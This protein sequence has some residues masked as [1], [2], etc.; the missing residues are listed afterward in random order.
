MIIVGVTGSFSS[1][2]SAVAAIFKKLGAK[3]FDADLAAHKVTQKGTAVH[4]AIIQIFGEEFLDSRGQLDRKKLAKRVF[5]HPRDLQKLNILV[6]P[7]VI[8]E[9]LKVIR[10]LKHKKGILVLDV[11]LL[12]EARMER[13]AD[14][15]VVVNSSQKEMIARA[16]KK[17]AAPALSRKILSLQ[18]PFSKKARHADYVIHNRGNMK[19]LKQE[20]KKIFQQIH[21]RVYS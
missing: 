20:V 11:P 12:Y 5:S 6:H 19:E 3:V 17:G 8:F 21:D 10:Q 7:E 18:W 13:L 16:A 4:R 14:F 9:A 2:K 15:T 1:G